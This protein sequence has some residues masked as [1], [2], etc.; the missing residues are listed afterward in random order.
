MPHIDC[1]VDSGQHFFL[2][3][4]TFEGHG[5]RSAD[6]SSRYAQ[7]SEATRSMLLSLLDSRASLI[8]PRAGIALSFTTFAKA[9]TARARELAKAGFARGS[10][11]VVAQPT[12]IEYLRDIFALWQ[13]GAMAVAVNPAITPDERRTV[14]QATGALAM[15]ENCSLPASLAK[16]NEPKPLGPDEPALTLM[17]SGTTGSPK[18]IVHTQRSLSA[19]LMLNLAAIGTRDLARSLC[20]LPLHFGHGLIGNCLTVIAAGGT[21]VLWPQPTLAELAGFSRSI[22]AWDITFMSSTPAFW[23]VA[24]RLSPRPDHQMRRVHVGSS[25]LAIERW[26]DIAGWT[27]TSR[28][29][30]MYGMT[31]TANWIGGACLDDAGVCDGFVGR[32]WGGTAALLGTDGAVISQGE[33]EVLVATPAMMQGYLARQADTRAAFHREWLRT[34]DIGRIDAQGRLTLVGRIKN[35]IN[36]AGVKISVEEIDMLLE[37]HPAIREACAFGLP[38]PVAGEAVAAAIVLEAPEDATAIRA[39]CQQRCRAE[40]VP[41]RLFVMDVIPRNDRGKVVRSQVRD[42]ALATGSEG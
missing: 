23:N 39:W 36:R 24:M 32:P 6:L 12:P 28:V 34:G 3:E 1:R 10:C 25:P 38:D 37:R 18:G 40:A 13:T 20:V 16:Q 33:G 21:L 30:N 2:G 41:S 17:T 19:R 9:V 26:S 15:L 31:E 14:M 22:K 7:V 8:D 29:F 5:H 42:A 27:G 4:F 11:G 35:E